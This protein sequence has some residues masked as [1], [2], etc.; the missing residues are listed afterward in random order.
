[1]RRL[2]ICVS[3]IVLSVGCSHPRVDTAFGRPMDQLEPWQ[4]RV[5]RVTREMVRNYLRMRDSVLMRSA[6]LTMCMPDVPAAAR[7]SVRAALQSPDITLDC[8]PRDARP[9]SVEQ[10]HVEFLRAEADSVLMS[11]L[12]FAPHASRPSWREIVVGYPGGPL[13]DAI[14]LVPLSDRGGV[15]ESLRSPQSTAALLLRY[16][17]IRQLVGVPLLSDTACVESEDARLLTELGALPLS[18]GHQHVVM[19]GNCRQLA[20]V[21]ADIFDLDALRGSSSRDQISAIVRQWR[22]IEGTRRI[23]SFSVGQEGRWSLFITLTLSPHD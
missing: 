6:H 21:G 5:V 17:E 12:R 11:A 4:R 23:E 15:N 10:L 8:P 20:F 14:T 3:V 9:D 1:M 2:L 7:D 16:F 19:A 13:A 18:T 22:G